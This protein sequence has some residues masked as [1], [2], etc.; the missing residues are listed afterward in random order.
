MNIN[1]NRLIALVLGVGGALLLLVWT[2]KE[3][4]AIAPPPSAALAEK[5][6][7]ASPPAAFNQYREMPEAP[8]D[9]VAAVPNES[10]PEAG[11]GETQLDHLVKSV[12]TANAEELKL[13]PA[14]VEL[15][16]SAYIEY[17]EVHAELVSRYLQE[18]SFDPASVTLR[19]PA[20]P[21]EGKL[22]RDMFY[23]RLQSDFPGGKAA[24]IQEQMGG[25]FDN[26]F[27]GFGVTEQ[28]FTITRSPKVADAFE[29]KW[30][31]NIPE[32]QTSGAAN[33]DVSFA[34]SSG[35]MLL[36]REQ[37]MTGEFRFLGGAL[38]RRFPAPAGSSA[39]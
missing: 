18:T 6:V 37:V 8:A 32:G 9:D 2:R 26:A 19:L 15:L 10:R 3:P 13:T 34:G 23:R 7:D 16:A 24:E 31:A 27:R 39:R 11:T 17:Q 4:P 14:Q 30:A 22:L 20:H 12:I 1:K 29:V 36:Y 21:V 35:T 25:F 33:P 5:A 28:S 38:E